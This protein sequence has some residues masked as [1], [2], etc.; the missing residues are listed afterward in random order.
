MR[1]SVN[2]SDENEI[3]TDEEICSTFHK[4]FSCFAIEEN[5]NVTVMGRYKN[6]SETA[7]GYSMRKGGGITAFSGLGNLNGNILRKFAHLSGVHLYGEDDNNTLY[8]SRSFLGVYHKKNTD[9]FI[10]LKNNEPSSWTDL[11]ENKKYTAKD[12][13]KLLIPTEI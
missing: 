13:A 9:C 5:K 12:N 8:I 2:S 1:L 3:I 10:T 4:N 6:S 7:I 11:F